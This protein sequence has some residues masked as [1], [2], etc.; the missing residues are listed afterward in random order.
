MAAGGASSRIRA[1]KTPAIL[2][3][4]VAVLITTLLAA[5]ALSARQAP[6]PTIAEFAPKAIEQIK[7]APQEQSSAFGGPGGK[8]TGQDQGS[9]LAGGQEEQQKINVPRVRRCVGNPPRQTEDPK[10]PPC[11][12]YFDGDNGG[13]TWKGV[14]ATEIKV[15][16][17]ELVFFEDRAVMTA[18]VN[19]FNSR[20]E[21]YGRKINL[22]PYPPRDGFYAIPNPANMQADAVFVDEEM[23]AF[24]SISYA[25]RFGAEHHY[26]D[27][28]ARRKIVSLAHRAS[29]L[30]TEARYKDYDPYEWN[31]QP[32]IDVMLRLFG[33]FVCNSIKDGPPKYAGGNGGLGTIS[34]RPSRTIGM[35]YGEEADGTT[36]P[37]A[38]LRNVLSGCGIKLGAEFKLRESLDTAERA[39]NSAAAVS[40]M[41]QAQPQVT[42][43][44]C[45]CDVSNLRDGLMPAATGQSYQ[46]EWLVSTY[47]DNDVDNSFRQTSFDQATHVIGVSYRD[48]WL[49]NQETPWWAAMKEGQPG[50]TPGDSQGYSMLA[51]Y[52]SLLTLASGIQLAGPKLTPTTFRDGLLRT[53]FPNPGAGGP[54]YYQ[55][56][57]G[58]FGGRHTLTSS[59]TMIWYGRTERSTVEPSETGA[60]CYVNKGARYDLGGWPAGDPGFF[61]QPCT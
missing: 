25:A 56:E 24:A 17:P 22:T 57:M 36:P 48:K 60:V 59:A 53:Q 6:P 15:A 29:A 28:L 34:A 43:V 23:K 47:I 1:P 32:S 30:G 41:S 2:Y 38:L 46:P 52:Q 49:P 21:F 10:S 58:F 18:M 26:Y 39:Q 31:T 51:R 61:A 20:Y 44:I 27:E 19:H 7:D 11:V 42:T 55:A 35:I 8:G 14:T 54:P 45:W 16:W 40:A 4:V 5:F 50:Y 37:M 13:A 33:E 9:G 3:T 12:P